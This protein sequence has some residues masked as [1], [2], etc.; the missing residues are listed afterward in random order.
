MAARPQGAAVAAP[1]PARPALRPQAAR[2]PRAARRTGVLGGVVWIVVLA[3]LL[4]GIV[5][6]NVAALQL[7]VALQRANER[8]T[9][10]RAET[11]ALSGRLS[12]AGSVPQVAFVADHRL[13]L[14]PAVPTYLDLA[15]RHRK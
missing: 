2:R 6:L 3:V 4:G 5:A 12:S 9:E 13:G 14:V 11:A 7:N 10:L 1:I 15:A 8:K